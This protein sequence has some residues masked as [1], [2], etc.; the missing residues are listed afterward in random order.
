MDDKR[1][2]ILLRLNEVSKKKR[3]VTFFANILMVLFILLVM[4]LSC[5]INYGYSDYA[6]NTGLPPI[7]LVFLVYAIKVV[8]VEYLQSREDVLKKDLDNLYDQEKR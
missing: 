8:T 5:A 7:M 1:D 4:P 3:R 2:K 6:L